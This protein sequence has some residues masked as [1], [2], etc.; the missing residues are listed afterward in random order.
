MMRI[1]SVSSVALRS[2]RKAAT[3][4][5]ADSANPEEKALLRS[6]KVT[7]FTAFGDVRLQFAKGLNVVVGEN[8]LGKT[9][10]LKLPYSI[11]AASAEAGRRPDAGKPTKSAL[12]KRL[13]EKMRGVFRPESLGRLTRRRQGRHRC[14]VE[15]EF[16]DPSMSVGF[17]FA[18]QSISEVTVVRGAT[19]WCDRMPVFL[20]TRELLTIYPGFVSLYNTHNLEFEEIWRDTC[21]LLGAPTLRGP[22]AGATRLLQPLEERMGG[23]LVLDASGRFYLEQSGAGRFEM[24]LVAEGWRKLGMVARLIATGSLR[25]NGCLFWDEPEA[26]LNPKLV[27]DVAHAILGLC[28]SGVQVVVATHSLFLLREFDML[29]SGDF[30]GVKCRYFALRHGHGGDDVEV[31]QGDMIDDVEPLLALDEDL[32]QSDRFL[33]SRGP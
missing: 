19:A 6:L 32:A 33:E 26:N 14:A 11:A 25:E 10:L 22:H 1:P 23:Q 7:N 27:R 9:H 17:E 31:S 3:L 21:L 2:S 24:P 12:Q 30:R 8:G 15:L 4:R 28:K 13:A 5:H 20:P 16:A 29:G 18:G